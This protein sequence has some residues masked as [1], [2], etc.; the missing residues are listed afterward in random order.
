MVFSLGINVF[1]DF[2]KEEIMAESF[3]K[4]PLSCSGVSV[5]KIE[6]G[7]EC[8]VTPFS[9][10]RDFVIRLRKEYPENEYL[11][12]AR[13]DCYRPFSTFTER[14]QIAY[15]AVEIERPMGVA[16]GY[17]SGRESFYLQY[18]ISD[19]A[20]YSGRCTSMIFGRMMADFRRITC[21]ISIFEK[22]ARKKAIAHYCE[23]FGFH[24]EPGSSYGG[25]F[26]FM[27]WNV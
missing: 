10:F 22:D 20:G 26:L 9:C 23:R 16:I 13:L 15:V 4:Y 19:P 21:S 5:W 7:P 25:D 24:I 6:D 12:D 8:V 3:K 2:K 17:V 11:S 18:L 1:L 27:V 14:K